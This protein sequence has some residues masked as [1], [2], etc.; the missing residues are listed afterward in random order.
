[1]LRAV[2][3]SRLPAVIDTSLQRVLSE[4]DRFEYQGY[5][6]TMREAASMLKRAGEIGEWVERV[7][8]TERRSAP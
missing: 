8:T 6:A 2:F 3:G 4:K 1:M 7:L 5:L